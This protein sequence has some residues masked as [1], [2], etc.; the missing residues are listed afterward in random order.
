MKWRLKPKKMA[1]KTKV[2]PWNFTSK[3]P[4]K[5]GFPKRKGVSQATIFRVYDSFR[6]GFSTGKKNK[7]TKKKK[8]KRPTFAHC[9]THA[10]AL[11]TWS[12]GI[13]RET[14]FLKAG[15]L[16]DVWWGLNISASKNKKEVSLKKTSFGKCVV[17]GRIIPIPD[18]FLKHGTCASGDQAPI[19]QKAK[20]FLA[21]K[22]RSAIRTSRISCF[23]QPSIEDC[24]SSGA[25][26]ESSVG[27]VYWIKP[28][29]IDGIR[30]YAKL[31]CTMVFPVLGA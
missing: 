3:L 19:N 27:R 16:I 13:A 6:E 31:A 22:K 4:W 14:D 8:K 12:E 10:C 15:H 2:K 24:F 7:N 5:M 1:S 23:F 21:G 9:G 18:Y 28:R 17:F 29:S 26:Q 20:R 11:I 25:I 30:H